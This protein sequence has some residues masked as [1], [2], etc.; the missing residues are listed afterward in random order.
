VPALRVR[1]NRPQSLARTLARGYVSARVSSTRRGVVRMAAVLPGATAGRLRLTR[2]GRDV[3]VGRARAGF[4]KAGTIPVRVRLSKPA[5]R[6]FGRARDLRL[7]LV[8]KL[9]GGVP[10][11]R[12]TA[13]LILVP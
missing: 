7:T 4:S 12:A 3:V 5:R 10:K 9:D 13:S 6:H 8:A 2:G 1:I 11:A